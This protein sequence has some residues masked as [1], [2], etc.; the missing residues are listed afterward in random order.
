MIELVFSV[1][2]PQ[3]GEEFRQCEDQSWFKVQ[4]VPV[5]FVLTDVICLPVPQN[6]DHCLK[7]YVCIVIEVL[8][9]I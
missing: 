5:L 7:R 8:D 6:E 2:A 4:A 9:V 1:P 3:F